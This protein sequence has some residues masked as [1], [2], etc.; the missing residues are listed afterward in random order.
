MN[1]VGTMCALFAPLPLLLGEV[2]E[3]DE[4]DEEPA[5]EDEEAAAA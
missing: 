1:E 2:A 5:A 4:D 3:E